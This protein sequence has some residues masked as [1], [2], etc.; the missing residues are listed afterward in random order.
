MSVSKELKQSVR[1]RAGNCCEYC[2]LSQSGRMARF[3]VQRLGEIS[4][5]DYPCK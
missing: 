4:V 3:H 1:D 2:L 5:G